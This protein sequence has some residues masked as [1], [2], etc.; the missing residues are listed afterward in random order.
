[1]DGF[2]FNVKFGFD[3]FSLFKNARIVGS[4]VL[5]DGLYKLKLDNVFANSLLTVHHN[6][7][8]KHSI[9]DENS[10]CGINV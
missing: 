2:G 4:G 7:G 3:S 10:I 6:I 5:I 8:I 9:L 1:L